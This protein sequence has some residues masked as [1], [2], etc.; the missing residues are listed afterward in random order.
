[1]GAK[2]STPPPPPPDQYTYGVP[3]KPRPQRPQV[4]DG[5]VGER[6]FVGRLEPEIQRPFQPEDKGG[7]KYNA[8]TDNPY[9]NLLQLR[10]SHMAD[11]YGLSDRIKLTNDKQVYAAV[12]HLVDYTPP[13]DP[14]V[15]VCSLYIVYFL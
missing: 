3:G 8:K 15:I 14:N 11:Y 2:P 9:H 13:T 10:P 4:H 12:D 1:M 7:P 6:R 5:R